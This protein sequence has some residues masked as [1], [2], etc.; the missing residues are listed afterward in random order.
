MRGYVILTNK[1]ISL[2]Y[3]VVMNVASE[4]TVMKV[5][6]PAICTAFY[7]VDTF[8]SIPDL[9]P[10]FKILSDLTVL[11]LHPCTCPH[12]LTPLPRLFMCE[13][14]YCSACGGC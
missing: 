3:C 7:L 6:S 13:N 8:H 12:G 10:P 2:P 9:P 1:L 4:N 11:Y 5:S 14:I